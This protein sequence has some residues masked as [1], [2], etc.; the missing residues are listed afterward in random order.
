M[1]GI[2]GYIGR[3]NATEVI[4]DGLKR[5]EYRGY[6]SA[7]LAL[8]GRDKKIH[9]SRCVGKIEQLARQA[10]GKMPPANSGIGHTRWA[11][12]GIPSEENAHPHLD[13]QRNLVLVHN[14]IIE[15]YHLIKKKLLNHHFASQ[16]DT[17]VIVHLLEE[18]YRGNILETVR[19]TLPLLRGAYALAIMDKREP[20]KIIGARLYAP[21]VVGL[22]ERENFLASDV[23]AILPYS[24]QVI[25]LEDGDVVELTADKV[26]IFNS[27]GQLLNRTPQQITW[28]AAQAE[29]GGYKH[30]MLK[31]I[32]EQPQ[33]IQDTMRGRLFIEN[34]KII[35]EKDETF[36][37]AELKNIQRVF[38]VACGTSYHAGLIG[39]FWLE[40]FAGIP[41]DVDIASEFRYRQPRVDKNTLVIT[42][43]QSGETADT[44]AAIC[45]AK[46]HQAPTLTICNT[47][48][49][50]AARLS[51]RVF[52]IRCGPEIGVASTK[53]FTGQL[54]ALVLLALDWAKKYRKNIATAEW[55]KIID[56]LWEM[57]RKFNLVLKKEKEISELA[58]HYFH[59]Q[60][61]LYLGRNF[62]YP[63][64]LEGA[65]KLKEISYIHAEGYPAGEM[66][67]GP[68]AL[69]DENMPVFF[70][71]TASKVIE[72][73]LANM[74][75]VRSRQGQ[76]IAL[77]TEGDKS[78][79]EKTT[80]IFYL[81]EVYEP[82]SPILNILPLQLFA[83]YVA[84]RRGCDVDQPRNLAKSVTVE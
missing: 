72:K 31:E 60:N 46:K 63:V 12:H 40:N 26:K 14:G 83:Y 43:T 34:N 30:F 44:L 1:C 77:A 66:K 27:A 15:N 4:L 74:E 56:S 24:R 45:L 36:S 33:T 9:L 59:Q 65:L 55:E 7:G 25:F 41:V 11:T 10:L 51:D 37:A 64:A 47:V 35:L 57:P 70:I 50:S 75:E 67:H 21:L 19:R 17:E 16:T 82:L 69:I 8:I 20:D 5:L 62:N 71:A 28:T 73:I 81:P 78:I 61:F 58:E 39:K 42:I 38:L 76:I 23:T 49:S 48:G 79:K 29:K 52:Y 68:I 84:V 53:A 22:G 18:K 13:C 32:Y 80:R 3:R 54:T 6:D 2:V